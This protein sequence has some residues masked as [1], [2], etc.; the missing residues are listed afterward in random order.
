MSVVDLHPEELLDKHA[1]GT[2]SEAERARLEGHVS[3][4][5]VCRFELAARLHFRDLEDDE[6]PLAP[7]AATTVVPPRARRRRAWVIGLAAALVGGMSFAALELTTL[8]HAAAPE[9][10]ATA[11]GVKR[12]TPVHPVV[13]SLPAPNLVVESTTAVVAPHVAAEHVA[14]TLPARA[15]TA[16]APELFRAAN[17][18]RRSDD[19]ERAI[20]LYKE[21]ETRY[22]KSD[23]ARVSYATVGSL[24]LDRGDPRSALDGFNHY[25]S[26]GDGALGEEALVG[27]ALAFQRLGQ[28]DAEVGAWQEIL[29][30]FP[31]SVHARLAK[32]RLVELGQR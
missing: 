14:N 12:V 25:L 28:H 21:L 22:P 29:R 9:T 18:A 13:T 32:S 27:R 17:A 20:G 31:A 8:N 6:V 2:L 7:P 19:T 5:N 4:C 26:R 1:R 3:T 10:H 24:L 16:S 11:A 30:R 23:E 15:K